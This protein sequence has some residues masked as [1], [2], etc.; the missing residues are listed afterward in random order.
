[1]S[2]DF[3]TISEDTLLDLFI[4]AEHDE[5]YG[6]TEGDRSEAAEILTAAQAELDR[7]GI[8]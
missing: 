5:R 8:Q 1:M 4:A 7:R 2:H 3:S 6:D